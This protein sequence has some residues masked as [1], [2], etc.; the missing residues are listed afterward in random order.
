MQKRARKR[1]ASGAP[2]RVLLTLQHHDLEFCRCSE[3]R[4]RAEA[5]EAHGI[6]ITTSNFCSYL[7]IHGGFCR[8]AGKRHVGGPIA[9]AASMPIASQG[10]AVAAIDSARRSRAFAE[11]PRCAR[12]IRRN[13]A[14]VRAR[15]NQIRRA[16]CRIPPERW[17]VGRNPPSSAP[18]SPSPAASASPP[19]RARR[20]AGTETGPEQSKRGRRLLAS[21]P[22]SGIPFARASSSHAAPLA[23]PPRTASHDRASIVPKRYRVRLRE[24]PSAR[25]LDS[26]NHRLRERPR[27]AAERATG[28]RRRRGKKTR[29]RASCR[30]SNTRAARHAHAGLLSHSHRGLARRRHASRTA[31]IRQKPA[32]PPVGGRYSSHTAQMRTG[33]PDAPSMRGQATNTTAP[34]GGTWSRLAITSTCRCPL[35]ST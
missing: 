35:S 1:R 16:V 7:P 31:L 22:A 26:K 25:A 34:A 20:T 21:D 9:H 19:V 2:V 3:K 28:S 24:H 27:P 32:A 29:P 33:R 5:P 11:A 17:P 30:R 15:T 6:R 8:F 18:D 4:R 14:A 13:P 12:P 23:S 10:H